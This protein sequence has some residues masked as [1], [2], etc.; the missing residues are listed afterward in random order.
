MKKTIF[1]LIATFSS[2]FVFVNCSDDSIQREREI[3]VLVESR[4]ISSLDSAL[5]QYETDLKSEGYKVKIESGLTSS[6]LPTEIKKILQNEYE[7]NENLIGAVFIG[8]IQA[9]LFNDFNRQGDPYWH[10]YL[11]D[12]YYMDLNGVWEDY[13]N[14]G[15]YDQHKYSETKV[16]NWIQKKLNIGDPL[17]PE[18]WV[19]RIKADNL[20]SLGNE[21]EL[22]KSYF[23][24]N[25]NY[26]TGKMELPPKRAFVVADGVKV[27]KSGWGARPDLLY[28]DINI[29]QCEDYPSDSL[30]KFLSSEEGYEWGVVNVFSGPRIHHFDYMRNPFNPEWW[31][32]RESKKN[33]VAY[34]D[35]IHQPYDISWIDIKNLEPDVLFYHLLSSETGRFDVPDYLAGSYIFSGSGLVAI[36]GT[37]HSG[38]VGVPVFY[39]SLAAG[40]TFGESWKNALSYLIENKGNEITIYWCDQETTE[41]EGAS[42]YKAV[43]I[44]DGTLKIPQ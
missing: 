38:A 18:I 15:V 44:G 20:A 11:A 6:T 31:S 10:N 12:F 43:L 40:K 28:T 37:Q 16:I 21:I 34:S 24:K 17:K 42:V 33:I 7:E 23:E 8:N 2:L 14:N 32:T 27:F 39:E 25:H 4:L 3:M 13:D 19:S 9:P 5:E 22:L 35:T 30:R 29:V 36:A 41:P 1:L 26:R